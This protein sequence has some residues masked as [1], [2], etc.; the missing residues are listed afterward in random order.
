[1]Q[2]YTKAH[3]YLIIHTHAQHLQVAHILV[4]RQ[5]QRTRSPSHDAITFNQLPGL[6]SS[7]HIF[8]KSLPLFLLL[9]P[10]FVVSVVVDPLWAKVCLAH[11]WA[12][13]QEVLASSTK[14]G[15]TDCCCWNAFGAFF[16]AVT[17]TIAVI[18]LRWCSSLFLLFFLSLLWLEIM[19][20]RKH[21]PS[22]LL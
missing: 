17:T 11:S 1:M 19:L 2:L 20:Q 21:V 7:T 22:W 3:I 5:L 15:S 8:F 4:P 9:P 18:V 10:V 13:L 12:R 14:T 16:T 6:M